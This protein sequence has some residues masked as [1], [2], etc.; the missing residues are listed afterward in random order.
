MTPQNAFFIHRSSDYAEQVET[1]DTEIWYDSKFKLEQIPA[2]VLEELANAKQLHSSK[3][4]HPG[5]NRFAPKEIPRAQKL[6]NKRNLRYTPYIIPNRNDTN[7]EVW[8]K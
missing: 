3:M 8:F 4:D 7:Q 2:F 6:D 1:F 5:Y